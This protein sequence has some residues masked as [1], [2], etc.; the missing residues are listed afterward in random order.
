MFW[1]LGSAGALLIQLETLS[2]SLVQQC[3][4]V[5]ALTA[6]RD[7]L[8][9][10]RIHGPIGLAQIVILVHLVV[11]VRQLLEH[12]IGVGRIGVVKELHAARHAGLQRGLLIRLAES[13]TQHRIGVFR[14]VE[15]IDQSGDVI[16]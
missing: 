12:A 6:H 16:E 5:D 9:A 7:D 13:Q 14:Q 2:C 15:Q 10:E 1:T 11:E 4:A 3:F 8:I